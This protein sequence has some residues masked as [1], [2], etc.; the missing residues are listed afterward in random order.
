[1]ISEIFKI[2]LGLDSKDESIY[3]AARKLGS[4]PASVIACAVGLKRG[5]TYNHLM[6]MVELGIFRIKNISG[7]TRFE[8]MSPLYIRGLIARRKLILT[9]AEEKFMRLVLRGDI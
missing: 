8:A 4:Q 2:L 7:V 9:R 5:D 1:M 3:I 6:K